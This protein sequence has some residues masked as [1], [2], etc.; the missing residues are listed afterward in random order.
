ML[1]SDSSDLVSGSSV[2]LQLSSSA[3]W[4]D[5]LAVAAMAGVSLLALAAL[6]FA[7]AGDGAAVAVVFAP[8]TSSRLAFTR[9]T[10]AGARFVRFG[11]VP[12][13][14]V[15]MPERD[16]YAA[17]ARAAG[18]LF[19]ADPQALAACLPAGTRS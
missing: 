4:F 13:V 6:T 17:R 19:T 10:D 11:G 2:Q 1:L 9:A 14:V 12:F 18:A 8:W 7:P 15:V 5:R 3:A 16:G